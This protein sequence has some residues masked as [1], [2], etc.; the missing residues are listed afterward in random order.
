[1]EDQFNQ[2]DE[3]FKKLNKIDSEEEDEANNESFNEEE[4]DDENITLYNKKEF[5]LEKL[6]KFFIN[7][8]IFE[9]IKFC[10]KCGKLMN[11]EKNINYLDERVWRCRSKILPHDE[12]KY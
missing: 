10:P 7:K 5:E 8:D 4:E 9:K 6:I 11:L 3:E 1:M 2:N 12:K